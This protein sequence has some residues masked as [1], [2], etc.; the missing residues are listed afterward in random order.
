MFAHAPPRA[1][2]VEDDP[3]AQFIYGAILD[4]AGL[5]T[6][7]IDN[8]R[9]AVQHARDDAPDVILMDLDLPL[10][11]GWQ[12]IERLREGT[13]TRTIPIIVVTASGPEHEDRAFELGVEAFLTKPVSPSDLVREIRRFVGP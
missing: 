8:G 4:A 6:T 7:V 9:A 1:L 13:P 10:M 5:E 2:L 3:H 12:A 11:D